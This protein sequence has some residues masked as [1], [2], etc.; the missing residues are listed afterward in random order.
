MKAEA[1][2]DLNDRLRLLEGIARG[3]SAVEEG[4]VVT[5]A[6]AK[7]RMARWLK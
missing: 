1:I 6:E 5:Q 3:E 2:D 4:R 7:R